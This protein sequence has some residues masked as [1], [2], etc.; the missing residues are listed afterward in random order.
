MI[1]L[2]SLQRYLPKWQSVTTLALYYYYFFLSSF[3]IYNFVLRENNVWPINRVNLF[4]ISSMYF[5]KDF[6]STTSV[7]FNYGNYWVGTTETIDKSCLTPAEQW[8]II[9][10]SYLNWPLDY[11]FVVQFVSTKSA[12]QQ[13]RLKLN[14]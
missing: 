11:S 4:N 3:K 14:L 10:R 7:Y 9:F 13:F 6:S 12:Q 1:L 5:I 2:H 8:S